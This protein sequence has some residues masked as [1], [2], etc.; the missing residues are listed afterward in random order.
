MKLF[1]DEVKYMEIRQEDIKQFSQD[2]ADLFLGK[3]DR[4]EYADK[5]ELK[6]NNSYYHHYSLVK[7]SHF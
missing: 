6:I 7:F 3:K 2:V 1:G 4:I 5:S